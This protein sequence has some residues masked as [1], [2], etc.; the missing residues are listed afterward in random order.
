MLTNC[1]AACAHLTISVFGIERDI[2]EKIV[3]LSYPLAFDAAVR[4]VPVGI[5]A[6]PLV[7]KTRMVSLP[8]G[9]KISKICLFVLTWSTNVTDG[10]ADRQTDTAWHQRPR[11]CIA[12][13][14][15]NDMRIQRSLSLHF[16]LLYLRLNNCDRNSGQKWRILWHSVVVRRCWE[17]FHTQ[18]L[19]RCW[20]R[21]NASISLMSLI[22]WGSL[23]VHFGAL[24]HA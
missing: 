2:C 21:C 24:W 6:P 17:P 18:F 4:E 13:R 5:S 8:D 19:R 3:I 16:Y 23:T 12:S 9:D 14:G 1:L 15:K 22:Q 20:D 10:R 7:R 11:L